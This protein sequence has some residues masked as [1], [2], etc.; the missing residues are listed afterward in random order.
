MTPHRPGRT[1]WPSGLTPYLFGES[2][3]R[4]IADRYGREKLAEISTAYSGRGLPFLVI[5][6]GKRVLRKNYKHLWRE[7]QTSLKNE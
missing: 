7:W 5:S 1:S 3:T 2:F 6:T 4:Y